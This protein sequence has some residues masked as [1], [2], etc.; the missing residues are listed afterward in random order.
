MAMKRLA[1]LATTALAGSLAVSA[2]HAQSTGSQAVEELVV[3]ASRGAATID[4]TMVAETVAK[5]RSTITAEYI[6]TQ[7]PGQSPLQLINLVP[8]VNFTN[9]D[10]YGSS[11]GNIRIR[12]FDGNRISLLWDGM[13]LNDSG[14]YAI[15]SSQLLDTEN[16]E[17]VQVNVGTTDVDSPTASATGGTINYITRLPRKEFGAILSLGFGSFDY[18]R[19]FAGFDTGEIGP[20]D[21]TAFMT[22]SRQR[23][24]KFKGPGHI[25]R[26]QFNGRVY[27][28][29]GDNGDFVS[30]AASWN[31]GRNNFYRNI[32]KSQLAFYNAHPVNGVD[33]WHFD[34]TA[35]CARPLPGP[36]AQNENDTSLDGT[37][38]GVYQAATD[39]P[40]NPGACT[41][42]YNLRFNPSDTGNIRVNSSFHLADNVR[43]TVDPSFQYVLANGG[44][45]T[46]ISEFGTSALTKQLLGNSGLTVFDLNGDGD[47]ADSVRFY[48]PNVTNT[49]R[50]GLSSSLIWN[51]TDDHL[52]RLAYTGDFARHR[53]TGEWTYLTPGGDPTNVFGGKDGHGLKVYGPDGSYL[54]QRDRYSEAIL[55]QVALDYNGK[56]FDGAVKV[57]IGVRA[58]YFERQLNNY[59][60]TN[61]AGFG[62][63]TT[64]QVASTNADGT[65]ILVGQPGVR[66]FPKFSAVKK[67]NKVLPNLGISWDFAEHNTLYASFAEGLSAP[68]TDNLYNFSIPNVQPE[69]TKSF[70][71][72]WRYHAGKVLAQVAIWDTRYEN[73]IV[74]SFDQDLGISIDRNVGEVDI[75]GVDGSVGFE[76]IENLSVYGSA[77]YNHSEIK[78]G[79]ESS[80]VVGGVTYTYLVPTTGKK[81]VE[82]PDWTV[83]GRV[84][85]RVAGF[86]AGLQGKYVGKRFSTDINDEFAPSYTVF[87]ADLRYDLGK[88]GL[89]H[90]MIQFNVINL[91]DKHYFGSVA[92]TRTNALPFVVQTISPSVITTT[93][94]ASPAPLYAISAPRTYQVTLRAAF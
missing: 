63:C 6:E 83:G 51:I 37:H 71:F 61:T 8:G 67:Y 60:Y 40:A 13:P 81:L 84:Q 82:T 56:F 47:T 34:N 20:W 23:Y 76:P 62:Y 91:F 75:W 30:V 50:Y 43:L 64:S 54:R 12:S 79:F 66:Y 86:T 65:V 24:D 26:E 92:T 16:I 69:I 53:Q 78:R 55:N 36:G 27:Q 29:I 77:S 38:G 14:N 2:A 35:T 70:D 52:L 93:I 80:V 85:Y 25:Q 1:F 39:N 87:D 46:V 5:T 59:C 45:T 15:F 3:T 11:G 74:S 32:S 48:T 88:L 42:Y 10:P 9:N 28:S 90:S 44:G 58:P 21:T 89:G 19:V 49:R 73:R 94:A 31:S 57:N 18:N 68:R 72:G 7:T 4:G 41:N 22:V 17:R 33:G